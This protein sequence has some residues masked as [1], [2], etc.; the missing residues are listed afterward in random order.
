[1]KSG[2][3]WI[4]WIQAYKLRGVD[5]WEVDSKKSNTWIWKTVLKL[6]NV[7]VDFVILN[8]GERQWKFNKK[9][10]LHS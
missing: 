6:R 9:K 10:V 2:S 3:L 5:F 4:A 8:N 1:M 7:A